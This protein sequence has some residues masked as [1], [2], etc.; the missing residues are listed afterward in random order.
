MAPRSRKPP[1]QGFAPTGEE[2]SRSQRR[3]AEARANLVPLAPG[4]RPGVVVVAT[5]A[6]AAL[7]LAALVP[8]AFGVTIG[9]RQPALS[10]IIGFAALMT[11][12]ASGLWQMRQAALLAFMGLLAIIAT[13]FSLLLILASDVAAAVEALAVIGA[14]GYLFFKLV[15]VLSRIQMP[16]QPDR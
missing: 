12:C 3:D 7:A 14:S 10:W 8:F 6:A 5:V 2:L 13:F 1:R 4:E 16:R 15:R 9:G 11:L